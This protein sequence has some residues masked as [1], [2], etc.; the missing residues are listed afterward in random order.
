MI[1]GMPNENS[2]NRHGILCVL[3]VAWFSPAMETETV[4]IAVVPV[5]SIS[6]SKEGLSVTKEQFDREKN[7]G[8]AV[9]VARA[10]LNKGIITQE[11]YSRIEAVFAQ[12]Y[13]PVI[14]CKMPDFA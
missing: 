3:V 12:K 7:Y 14:G 4:N 5:I 2:V 11:E 6:V 9:A 8:A 10:M 1:I 13:Q